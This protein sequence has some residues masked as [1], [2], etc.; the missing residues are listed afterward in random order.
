MPTATQVIS[1]LHEPAVRRFKSASAGF[2]LL[3]A[4]VALTIIGVVLVPVMSFLAESSRQ[5]IA[6]A[7][8]TQRAEAK[9]TVVAY[10]QTLNP[11]LT[12]TGE[13]RLSDQLK[14][15]WVSTPLV[16]PNSE[17]RLGGRLGSYRMGF[18]AVDVTVVRE[19]QDWFEFR[20]RKVGYTS[21]AADIAPMGPR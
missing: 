10:I 21:R 4:I 15:R 7:D 11:K 19:D 16:D 6:V 1:R 9:R 20:A 12:P 17:F 5:L 3:E 18:Y 8:A 2:T 14:I 13:D